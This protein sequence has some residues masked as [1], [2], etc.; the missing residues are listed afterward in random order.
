MAVDFVVGLLMT[1]NKH[2]SIWVIVNRLTKFAHFIPVKS[3][4]SMDKLAQIYVEEIIRLHGTLVSIV[5]DRR[6]QFTSKF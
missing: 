3:G 5:S 2:G 1:S 6:P 4:Y